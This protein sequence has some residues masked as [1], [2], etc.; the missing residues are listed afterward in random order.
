MEKNVAELLKS[1]V[2]VKYFN[3]RIEIYTKYTRKI[4]FD[5]KTFDKEMIKKHV[6]PTTLFDAVK[7]NAHPRIKKARKIAQKKSVKKDPVLI[8][9]IEKMKKTSVK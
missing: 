3:D 1:A 5:G 9:Y 6:I 2:D 4:N 7:E 8:A